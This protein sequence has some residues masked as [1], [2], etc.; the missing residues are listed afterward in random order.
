MIDGDTGVISV[1][2]SLDRED[3]AVRDL[4]GAIEMVVQVGG[5]IPFVV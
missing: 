4:S 3:P 5:V 2:K 1:A